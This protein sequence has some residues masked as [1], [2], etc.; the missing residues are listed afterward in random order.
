MQNY[1]LQGV[2]DLN[3][4]YQ[5]RVQPITALPNPEDSLRQLF[6]EL[7]EAI[8]RASG[9]PNL[10]WE[11]WPPDNAVTHWGWARFDRWTAQSQA[12]FASAWTTSCDLW[13]D[14]L[15][16][17]H[18]S[19]WHLALPF[20]AK[21]DKPEL[22]MSD[23]ALQYG[24]WLMTVGRRTWPFPLMLDCDICRARYY[25]DSVRYF[26]IR[27][28]GEPGICPRCG[29]EALFVQHASGSLDEVSVTNALAALR[30]L[31]D[32]AGVI[33]PQDFR[34]AFSTEGFSRAKRAELV[35]ALICAPD[36]STIKQALHV[37]QWIEVLRASGL[38]NDGWRPSRGVL[39]TA[40]DG[41][42]CRSLGERSI[43][44]WMHRHGIE[45]EIEP[46]WP[47]HPQHNPLGRLQ[48]S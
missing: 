15:I 24:P 23:L 25:H 20:V 44:D 13:V 18:G 4:P 36:A 9:Y 39:C 29:H 1:N 42:P 45:H 41:H 14:S 3:V 30:R 5:P 2:G 16:E 34:A 27:R 11:T 22:Q 43:D 47:A 35:A 19:A 48:T 31:A 17:H 46:K 12:Q 28:W 38:V 21:R 8:Q 37:K 7:E 40:T 6:P 10:Y 32:I 33:P 26:L